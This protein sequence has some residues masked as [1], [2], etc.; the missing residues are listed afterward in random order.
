MYEIRLLRPNIPIVLDVNSEK[1][2]AASLIHRIG[3][4]QEKSMN[5]Q[6]SINAYSQAIEIDQHFTKVWLVG[7]H[8]LFL[9][10]LSYMSEIGS[11]KKPKNNVLLS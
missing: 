5:Y 9:H 8:R 4:L 3:Q 11:L 10:L 1:S 2:K 7:H 6:Q